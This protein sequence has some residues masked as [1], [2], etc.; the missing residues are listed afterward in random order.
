MGSEATEGQRPGSD[1]GSAGILSALY[2]SP[3]APPGG[4]S[5]QGSPESTDPEDDGANG[6]GAAEEGSEGSSGGE[7]AAAD[8]AGE[9]AESAESEEDSSGSAEGGEEASFGS[10]DELFQAAG[11]EGEDAQQLKVRV[12][13]DHDE[14]EVPLSELLS[15]YQ[16]SSVA[17]KRLAEAKAKKESVDQELQSK[18]QEYDEQLQGL[19]ALVKTA[20]D[21]LDA[22]TKSVDWKQLREDS[23]EE[24]AAKKLEIQE[25]R[26]KIESLKKQA[27]ESYQKQVERQQEEAKRLHEEH[28]QKE[29]QALLEKL[30]DWKDP[31][32]AKSDQTR[33]AKYLREEGFSEQDIA[34]ASDHRL[35]V[36]ARKAMLYDEGRKSAA[37]KKVPPKPKKVLRPGSTNGAQRRSKPRSAVEVLYPSGSA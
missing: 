35:I 31:E 16:Q 28:L 18:V 7:S 2:P 9:G 11:L 26:E 23:P 32:K 29:Q 21:D 17:E 3:E 34:S 13:I 27:R 5:D 1:D 6:G 25:R 37:R 24:Y 33:L 19:A 15:G 36:M 12:R 8:S 22:E 20:E 30:P 14:R 4:P 10:L